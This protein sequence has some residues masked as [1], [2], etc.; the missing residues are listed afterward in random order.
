[1]VGDSCPSG[2]PKALCVCVSLSVLLTSC[3]LGVAATITYWIIWATRGSTITP[4]ADPSNINK[5]R[6]ENI[7]K[8]L[9]S[10]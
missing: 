7:F 2:L 10:I 9:I 6:I 1:M 5:Q 3:W 4:L 8:K